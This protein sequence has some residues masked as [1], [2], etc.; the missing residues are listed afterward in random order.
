MT[1]ATGKEVDLRM[2][3]PPFHIIVEVAEV[4]IIGEPFEV[5]GPALALGQQDSALALIHAYLRNEPNDRRYVGNSVWFKPLR[6]TPRF[7]S[8][9]T[10]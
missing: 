3:A 8:L 10:P 2:E 4:R 9:T 7:D 6:G 1:E 5:G